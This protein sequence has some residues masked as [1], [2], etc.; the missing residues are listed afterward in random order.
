MEE[1]ESERDGEWEVESERG[2]E[3]EVE[4][5][6]KEERTPDVFY[7][8]RKSIFLSNFQRSY[9]IKEMGF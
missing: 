6:R 4:R 3:W 1:I 8:S 7:T 9:F 5:E 2:R